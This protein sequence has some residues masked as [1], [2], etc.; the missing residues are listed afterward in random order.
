MIILATL[1]YLSLRI[2][3]PLWFVL[4]ASG[5]SGIGTSMFFPANNSA[6]MANAPHGT[7]GGISGLL[8]TMQNI[9]ILGSFVIT[10]TVAAASIPREVAFQVFIGTTNLKGGVSQ[11]F[12]QG[13]DAALWISLVFIAI[14]GVLSWLRGEETRGPAH[15][16][17]E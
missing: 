11:A 1:L 3:T 6:V 16:P 12:V 9:G 4:V 2:D 7:Y 8:R 15:E 14:A 5:V 17:R 10:I 13:I